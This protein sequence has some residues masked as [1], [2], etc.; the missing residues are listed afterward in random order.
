MKCWREGE[1]IKNVRNAR[2]ADPIP[3]CG[4]CPGADKFAGE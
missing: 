1:E 3:L 4:G 2:A